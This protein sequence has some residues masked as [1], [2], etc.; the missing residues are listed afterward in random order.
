MAAVW[1]DVPD[2]QPTGSAP[3]RPNGAGADPP[4]GGPSRGGDNADRRGFTPRARN[5]TASET[6]EAI[7][8]SGLRTAGEAFSFCRDLFH[9]QI[10]RAVAERVPP[11]IPAV[12]DAAAR[13][14]F[15]LLLTDAQQRTL[16][17][18]IG[19][20]PKTWPRLKTLVGC[21]PYHFLLPQDAGMLNAAGFAKGRANMTYEM[22]GRVANAGQFGPGQ[23]VDEHTREYRVA[24]KNLDP[25]DPLPG[26]EY[27]NGRKKDQILQVRVKRHGIQKKRELFHSTQKKQLLFP[28]PG[29]TIVLRETTRMLNARGLH[30]P[31]ITPLRVKALWPRSHGASTA[32]ILVGF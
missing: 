12:G 23:L 8:T 18:E 26:A 19:G 10:D 27:F 32:A 5:G 16:F 25:H 4:I 28:Q 3:E 21:P 29:E 24:P 14:A 9:S 2:N 17:L 30:K 31:S 22:S 20:A 7:E 6:N 1:T 11:N 15:L 13:T